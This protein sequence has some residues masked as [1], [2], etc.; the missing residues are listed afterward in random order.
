MYVNPRGNLSEAQQSLILGS[1]TVRHQHRRETILSLIHPVRARAPGARNGGK[2]AFRVATFVPCS[3]LAQHNL[4]LSV[5]R[6]QLPRR[7]FFY[8]T[9]H[10]GEKIHRRSLRATYILHTVA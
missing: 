10:D 3:H 4:S 1:T 9:C 8:T 5:N 7:Q 6:Q 2:R